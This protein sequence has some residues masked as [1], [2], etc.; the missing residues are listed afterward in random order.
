M[1]IKKVLQKHKNRVTP[2]RIAIFEFLKTRHLFSYND[3]ALNF[4]N[5]GRAS[6]FRTLNLFLEIGAIRKVEL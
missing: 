6:I 1:D 2:E 4:S 5:I 3:I